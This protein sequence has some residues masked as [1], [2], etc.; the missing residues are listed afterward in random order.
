[1]YSLTEKKLIFYA[2]AFVAVLL[3]ISRL[4][5]LR[6]NGYVAQFWHFNGFELLFQSFLNF[7]FCAA[8]AFLNL[9]LVK[10]Q[11]TGFAKV[12]IILLC[13][14]F[15][16][17]LTNRTG[18]F[19]AQH[20]FKNTIN[21]II[22]HAEYFIR[23]LASLVLTG[24]LVKIILLL[25]QSKAKDKENDQLREAYLNVQLELLKEELNPHFFFNAL[26]SLSAIVR[27]DSKLAQQ[28]ISHLS[29][30]FRYTLNRHE[31]NLV[32]LSDELAIFNSYASLQ[33]MR[34]EETLK[35]KVDV[36]QHYLSYQLPYMSLQP[37]LENAAKH[38]SASI[39][40]PLTVSVCADNDF[41]IIKNNLNE[42]QFKDESTGIGLAN[43]NERFRILLHREIEIEK[44]ENYFIVKLPLLK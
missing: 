9:R 39:E 10:L 15:L 12:S 21:D 37:L 44:S 25:R 4:L 16:L 27:E 23:L 6:Q 35:I 32:P 2:A 20:L 41:L 38:N 18:I 40:N 11:I 30:I 13:N 43:L 33:K 7:I 1:M 28:Y 17:I 24:I 22:L 5:A 31:K 14:I 19:I 42:V 26:S 8:V 36:P 29:K 3:N 34:M